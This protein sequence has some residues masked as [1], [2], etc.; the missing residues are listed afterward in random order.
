MYVSVQKFQAI[1]RLTHVW[2]FTSKCLIGGDFELEELVW[3]GQYLL[4]QI[5]IL[6]LYRIRHMLVGWSALWIREKKEV[7]KKG[8]GEL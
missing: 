5:E 1:N 7:G 3:S 4:S 8:S 6:W 2:I